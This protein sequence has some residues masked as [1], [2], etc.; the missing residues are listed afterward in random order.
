MKMTK[1][2]KKKKT[3]FDCR[4]GIEILDYLEILWK[5]EVHTNNL[6]FMIA[7]HLQQSNDFT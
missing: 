2:R 5:F 3:K 1:E 7:L 4:D 6:C